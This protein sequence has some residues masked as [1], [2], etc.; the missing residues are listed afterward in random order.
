MLL[1]DKAATIP[2]GNSPD[3]GEFRDAREPLVW[4]MRAD[5]GECFSDDT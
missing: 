1:A 3:P 4:A 2:G 5:L